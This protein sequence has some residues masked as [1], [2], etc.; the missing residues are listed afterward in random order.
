M[1]IRKCRMGKTTSKILEIFMGIQV[2]QRR[3]LRGPKQ[4]LY[5]P[6]KPS[7][8]DCPRVLQSYPSTRIYVH[9]SRA[10]LKS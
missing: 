10:K 6:P 3:R 5:P 4:Q 2:C 7:Q 1:R 9:E 8:F